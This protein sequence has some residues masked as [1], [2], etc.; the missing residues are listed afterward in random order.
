VT[1]R[2][3]NVEGCAEGDLRASEQIIV[4]KT[5]RVRGSLTAPR[6]GLDFGCK[7]NGS[8]DSDVRESAATHSASAVK[9][10]N[11]ADFKAAISGAGDGPARSAMGKGSPR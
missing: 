1:A 6:I 3:I 9:K 4:R 10:Q 8:I 11:I 7:F 5:G 2:V